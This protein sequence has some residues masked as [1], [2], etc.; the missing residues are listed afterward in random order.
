MT[1]T[2]IA[3]NFSLLSKLMDIHG[4]DSFKAKSYS[5]AAYTIE[6][7]Q[8]ELSTLES[9]KI[10]GL[11]GIGKSVGEKILEQLQTQKLQVLEDILLQTPPGVLEMLLNI[12]G[13]GPKKIATVWKE[14]EIETVGELLYACNENRLTL[15]KGF[16]EK[17][18]ASVKANIEFYLS[19]QGSYLYAQVQEYVKAMDAALPKIFTTCFFNLVGSFAQQ[20]DVIDKVEWVTNASP[21]NIET[22]F[23]NNGY[24]IEIENVT[25]ILAKGKENIQLVFYCCA[26]EDLI[27]LSFEKSC[28][29]E[30]Y[31]KISNHI[32][33]NK[34]YINEEDIFTANNLAYLPKYRRC[35]EVFVSHSV[36]NTIPKPI[37][38][39][40]IKGIIHS[41]S[42]WSDGSHSLE[43]M[44][45]AAKQ[46]GYEYLVISDHSKTAFYAQGLQ[47]EKVLAQHQQIEELNKELA[48][49]T[50]FKSIESDILGDGS[51]DYEEDILSQFDLIIASVHS[52][53]NMTKEK[54]TERLLTAIQNKYTSILGHMTGRLLLSRNGY[55]INHEL[56]INACI[57]N[58]VVIE[59]N[60]HPRRLDIDWSFIDEALA[61]GALISINPDAHSIEG[62]DDCHYG[63]LCAQ[64]T[65]LTPNKN[66]SSFSLQEF[67]EFVKVQ[68]AKRK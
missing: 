7:L 47:P 58:N 22:F 50:I 62:F 6:Q 44:A 64:K 46:K 61:K 35:N 37:E 4:G 18:Q 3:D 65:T 42:K 66:L 17:T 53:L 32:T 13:L 19:T 24:E 29:P 9:S 34:H 16:G 43:E 52:N 40:D 48:P 5:I 54:A 39:K 33:V 27:K 30:F 51:L 31:K 57:A 25:T 11:K 68:Q 56:I 36:N 45:R 28:S 23:T 1:N 67:R 63:V 12:K 41:H 55:P 59:L 49:F 14:M 2:A 38:T 21:F 10:F 60:A 8:V 26:S 15:Y 20:Q